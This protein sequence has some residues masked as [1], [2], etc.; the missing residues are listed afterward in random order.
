ASKPL[1]KPRTVWR[2]RGP[3]KCPPGGGGGREGTRTTTGGGA[4]DP[5]LPLRGT[6]QGSHSR[7][8]APKKPRAH[9]HTLTSHPDHPLRAHVNLC[10]RGRG[11]NGSISPRLTMR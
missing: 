8:L 5:P 7:R 4:G 10:G 6:R 9:T 3:P 1:R 11:G 2:F